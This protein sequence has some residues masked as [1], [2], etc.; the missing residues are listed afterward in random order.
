VIKNWLSKLIKS[1]ISTLLKLDEEKL[2]FL[3]LPSEPDPAIIEIS[4]PNSVSRK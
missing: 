1:S 2:E 4:N 3:S